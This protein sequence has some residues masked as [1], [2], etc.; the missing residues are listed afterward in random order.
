M[1]KLRG[2][3]AI[4]VVAS[5]SSVAI[6]AAATSLANTTQPV[7]HAAYRNPSGRLTVTGHIPTAFKGPNALDWKG[8]CE[9]SPKGANKTVLALS[10][11]HG[12]SV[13]FDERTK[14][15]YLTLT[16]HAG[17]NH[18]AYNNVNLKTSTNFSIV[19]QA[20]A[21]S[22]PGPAFRAGEHHGS[23]TLS[24]SKEVMAPSPFAPTQIGNKD[25]VKGTISGTLNPVPGHGGS[26][27]PV[28]LKA[29]WD[30]TSETLQL[31]GS[32]K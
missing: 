26:L 24:L 9:L 22:T 3:L 18:P 1:F 13:N 27:T 14:G 11:H 25:D 12:T 30:C 19:L 23:G 21:N 7:A 28:Q 31:A 16:M 32:T 15:F 29:S 20:R 8:G 5:V 10:F 6:A 2:K 17:I 4:A